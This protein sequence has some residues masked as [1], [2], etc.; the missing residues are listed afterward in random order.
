[1]LKK[2]A[3][4]WQKFKNFESKILLFIYFG[5]WSIVVNNI[6]FWFMKGQI[7]GFS[8]FLGPM[9]VVVFFS[10]GLAGIICGQDIVS[11]SKTSAKLSKGFFSGFLTFWLAAFIIAI[12]YTIEFS[13]FSFPIS[14]L[15]LVI[16]PYTILV[17]TGLLAPVIAGIAGA[18]LQFCLRIGKN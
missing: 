5:L 10:S 2:I 3:Y 15:M 12:I 14:I 9:T 17:G 7:N 4:L 11:V 1:M 16:V 18:L 8:L 6:F 13:F